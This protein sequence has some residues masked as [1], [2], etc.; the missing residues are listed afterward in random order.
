MGL[1]MWELPLAPFHRW[2]ETEAQSN[3]KLAQRHAINRK[4]RVLPIV[5]TAYFPKNQH[6]KGKMLLDSLFRNF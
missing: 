5:M 3:Q 2:E 1:F 6:K 4:L